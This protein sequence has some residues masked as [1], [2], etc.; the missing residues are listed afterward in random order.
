MFKLHTLHPNLQKICQNSLQNVNFG[1]IR[2]LPKQS[3]GLSK[4]SPGLS[5][6][7]PGPSKRRPGPSKQRPG[8]SKRRPDPPSGVQARLAASGPA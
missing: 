3:P 1:F 8:S 5:K 7:S 4:P 6:R 2:G